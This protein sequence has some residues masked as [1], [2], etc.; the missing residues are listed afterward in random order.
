MFRQT[1]FALTLALPAC[2]AAADE[3]SDTLGSALEAYQAGDI[4]YAL[5][6]LDFA[7][8]KLLELKT[9]A[10]GA[11]LP[12][13]PEGWTRSVNT[14]A[15]AAMAMMGGGVAAEADYQTGTGDSY[16]LQ[17]LADN[18]MVAGMA[19]MVSNAAAMGLK[20]ERVNRQRFA[21]QDQQVMGLIANR[22]FVQVDGP[23]TATAL[24]LLEA[25]DFDSLADFGQ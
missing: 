16:R 3:I 17:I 14:E 13:P 22:I 1:L 8:A 9:D 21:I 25:M 5:E 10:L 12:E 11:F 19:A 4:Q 18:P 2:P 6:E 24:T 20:T 7:R 15:N 23:D